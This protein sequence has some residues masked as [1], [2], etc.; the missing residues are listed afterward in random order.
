VLPLPFCL[1]SFPSSDAASLISLLETRLA[2]SVPA[3]KICLLK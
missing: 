2:N 3:S 1:K